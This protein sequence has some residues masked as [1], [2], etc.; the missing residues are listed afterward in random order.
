MSEMLDAA[1]RYAERG[2]RIVPVKPRAKR[3]L[4][5]AW[6]TAATTDAA[7]IRE[8]W[9][10]T[11]NANIGIATGE[12][13]NLTVIDPDARDGKPGVV[14]LTRLAAAHGG[15]PPTLCAKTGSG[16]LHL[17]FRY[18][19]RL[20]E[21][22]NRLAEAV[23][24]KST[25][26]FVVAP[27]SANDRGPYVWEDEDAP[28]LELPDWMVPEVRRPRATRATA[29][30]RK[31]TLDQIEGMLGCVDP[32]D[33]ERWLA[34]GVILGREF[35][36]RDEAWALYER[37]SARSAKFADDATGNL[38]RMRD[39]FYARSTQTVARG[40]ALTLGTLVHWAREGGW[41]PGDSDSAAYQHFF[42]I[43]PAAKLL[44]VP[45]GALWT[46]AA[47]DAALPPKLIDHN[48]RGEPIYLAASKWL[49]R[50]QGI[51]SMVFDPAMAQIVEDKVARQQGIVDQ[52]GARMFNTYYPP[53]IALGDPHAAQ[54]FIDHIHRLFPTEAEA[55]HIV[56]WLA[57]IV[58]R[59]GV[60][61]RHAL[62]IG[63]PQGVGKDTIIDA[64]V[65]ALGDWNCKSIAPDQIFSQFTEFKA[66]LLLR[67]NEVAD[68][69]DVSRYKFYEATKNL[70]SGSPDWTEVNPKYGCK[71]HVRNCVGV[72][73]TTNYI[74]T[75]IYLP[76]DDR[77]YFAVQTAA[78]P[79][80][81]EEREEYFRRLWGWL[82]EGGF[83]HV[84]AY[85][86]AV[87]LDGFDPNAPP[88]KTE[89]FF[90]IVANAKGSDAWLV[91]ALEE[92]GMPQMVRVDTLRAS[93]RSDDVKQTEIS[94]RLGAAMARQGY[95]VFR[96]ETRADGRH[97]F[98]D[99]DGRVRRVMVYVAREVPPGERRALLRGLKGPGF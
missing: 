72:V 25:G 71:F 87:P 41:E 64:A 7:Q 29:R 38:T 36:R 60:K 57:H 11:P 77:R 42:A 99:P 8:W 98:K 96:E 67:I 66:S 1:L 81:P 6:P 76:P 74:D 52:P 91:D 20:K 51:E 47:V 21:G 55:R 4:L 35:A 65:P 61:I 58:Q 90:S 75:G 56:R 23:D 79:F 86:H 63:G 62:L 68:L 45:S 26:G 34:V 39:M 24:V 28:I 40:E 95:A 19:E 16:G 94:P 27:P 12:Q 43:H 3:P 85:L 10:R 89:T 46:P 5:E 18:S 97:E 37:W 69:H 31:F 2:W 70:I 50:E 80:A 49:A 59:P 44:Y 84:A 53:N 17:Y 13:S 14:N 33:R 88:P 82:L 78:R 93:I 54:P 22:A 15:L 32:D 83:A 30:Q 48:E 9:R 73:L 92:L